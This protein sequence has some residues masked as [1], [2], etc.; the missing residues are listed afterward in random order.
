MVIAC[1]YANDVMVKAVP[2]RHVC[3][4]RHLPVLLSS[5]KL[6]QV[7]TMPQLIKALFHYLF[8]ALLL[9]TV[10]P[11]FADH[12]LTFSTSNVEPWGWFNEEYEPKG[13]LVALN[14]ALQKEMM[15]RSHRILHFTNHIRPYPRV[16]NDIKTGRADFAVL[17]NSRESDQFG[18]S[19][20]KVSDFKVLVTG[21]RDADSINSLQDLKGRP[22]GYVRGSRYGPVFDDNTDLSKVALDSMDKGLDMLLKGRLAALVCLDQTLFHALAK[23]RIP[24]GRT[25]TLMVLGSARADL[26][27]S[28]RS[29]NQS[30]AEI[31][32]ISLEALHQNGTIQAIFDQNRPK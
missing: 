10:N 25:Q 2:V 5:N 29:K 12:D 7:H 22:I 26:Y 19:V 13:L 23:K 18:E 17:F 21:L 31:A 14:T 1:C 20:G 11:V 16:I 24:A 4:L 30:L 15:H 32:E 9:L 8:P 3:L 27:I 28:R 6:C